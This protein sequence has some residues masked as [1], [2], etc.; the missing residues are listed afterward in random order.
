MAEGEGESREGG[1]VRPLH[2]IM[3]AAMLVTPVTVSAQVAAAVQPGSIATA[4]AIVS[5]MQIDR[6]M[7]PLLQQIMP[8]MTANVEHAILAAPNTPAPLK[9]RLKTDD[10]RKQVGAIISEEFSA[11]FRQRYPDIAEA[12]AVQYSNSSASRNWR[13]YLPF[14][15]LPPVPSFCKRSRNCSRCSQ[16]RAGALAVMR[17]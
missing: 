17:A 1:G 13:R 7:D 16:S 12:A 15:R 5:R 14:T 3:T 4:R 8:L 10:G 9:V 11:A 2:C 6:T